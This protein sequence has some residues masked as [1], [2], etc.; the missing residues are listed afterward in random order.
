MDKVVPIAM[1][2]IH[3]KFH[4][5]LKGILSG[6]N[7]PKILEIGSGHGAFTRL[8]W[9]DGY[10]VVA[11]DLQ[12]EYFYFDKLQCHKV[13]VTQNMP[14]ES[15]SFDMIIA[16]EVMEH[17][18]DHEVFFREADRVLRKGGRLLFSTPNILSLK[19]RLMFLFSGFF[20]SFKAIDHQNTDG[21]QHISSL[22]VNQYENLGL[23]NHLTLDDV[24]VDKKQHSSR[25]WYFLL[26]P[27][28]R[29]YCRIRHIDFRLHNRYLLLVGRILFMNLIKN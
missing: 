25:I 19:S 29:L 15:A 22:T 21:L 11:S 9:N 7:H 26:Y 2:G 1:P 23:R 4:L 5:Y 17:I 27:F 16:V 10:E 24:T 20:Y 13:D 28:I 3:E 8:L 6:Y 14:F 12:P 18:H